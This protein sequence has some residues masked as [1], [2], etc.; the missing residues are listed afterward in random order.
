MSLG[1]ELHT[2]LLGYKKV[3]TFST[4]QYTFDTAQYQT[5]ILKNKAQMNHPHFLPQELVLS[6]SRM[7]NA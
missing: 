4:K 7:K 3:H 5:T 2:D 6:V 1:T